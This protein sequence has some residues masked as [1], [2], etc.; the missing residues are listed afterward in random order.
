MGRWSEAKGREGDGGSRNLGTL[1]D[2]RESRLRLQNKRTEE[3]GS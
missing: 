3:K 1:R 2:E